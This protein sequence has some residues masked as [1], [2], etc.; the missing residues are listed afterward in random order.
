MHAE[1]LKK[2]IENIRERIAGACE[3]AGRKAAEVTL[4]AA[5]KTVPADAV[6]DA[7]RFGIT[8][9]GENRVQEYLEKNQVLSGKCSLHFIGQLQR[10][11]VKY[12]VSDVQCIHSVDR[13]SLMEEIEKQAEKEG[14]M[15]DI[16]LEVNVAGQASKAGV[17]RQEAARLAEAALCCRHLRLQ[18]LMT[19]PPYTENPEDAR[20]FF[21]ALAGLRDEISATLGVPLPHLSMGMSHDFEVAIE[22]GATYVRVG[23]SIFGERS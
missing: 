20:P 13:L 9:V 4:I 12:I 21:R 14:R 3:R 23:T 11:K 7:V 19:L 18:G 8:D 5:T 6:L 17:L 2:N 16:L 22:E 1:Q 15:M 10:N